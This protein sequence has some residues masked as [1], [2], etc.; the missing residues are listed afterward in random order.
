VRRSSPPG[1][2]RE[3]GRITSQNSRHRTVAA[4]ARRRGGFLAYIGPRAAETGAIENVSRLQAGVKTPVRAQKRAD[5]ALYGGGRAWIPPERTAGSKTGRTVAPADSSGEAQSTALRESSSGGHSGHKQSQHAEGPRPI[6]RALLF[7]CGGAQRYLNPMEW[8]GK[9]HGS[10][11]HVRGVGYCRGL[12][13]FPQERLTYHLDR[14]AEANHVS[15]Q[16]RR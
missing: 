15:R 10:T 3:N 7:R 2:P 14:D 16:R 11:G 4:P 13:L 12:P 8:N 6:R 9:A 5:V 1:A